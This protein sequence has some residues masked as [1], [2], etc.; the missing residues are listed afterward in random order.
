MRPVIKAYSGKFR[1]ERALVDELNTV[2]TG[3]RPRHAVMLSGGSTPIPAYRALAAQHPT[4]KAGLYL[5]FTD[6][7]YVPSASEASNYFQTRPLIDVLSLDERHVLR[8]RT[9]LP[10]DDAASQYALAVAQ[11]AEQGVPITLALLGLGA[12]GHT[13]SLFSKADLERAR[14][15]DAIAVARPDGRDAISITPRVLERADRVVFVV[16]G[17]DKQTAVRALIHQ[18]PTQTAWCAVSG[19][20][21]VEVW[22]DEEALALV[23]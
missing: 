7:R 10:L 18:D 19:C 4:A 21:H 5:L 13:C 17:S 9:E 14:A 3:V 2:I 6:D 1:L 11:L 20:R 22:A 15:A 16:S 23:D 8:V 12:D